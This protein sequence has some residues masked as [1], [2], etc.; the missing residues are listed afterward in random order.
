MNAQTAF[1]E[2]QLFALPEWTMRLVATG[3]AAGT[4][5]YQAD[6]FRD[7]EWVCMLALDGHFPDRA[8]ASAALSV[9]LRA[10]L[11]DYERKP[12]TCDSG[13]QVL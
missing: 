4:A 13:F 8:A 9:R 3:A 1:G 10:W 5:T 11:G 12:L 7:G 2:E 6:V